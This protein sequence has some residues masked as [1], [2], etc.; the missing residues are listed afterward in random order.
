M[1]H[2]TW[3][4]TAPEYIPRL[5]ISCPVDCKSVALADVQREKQWLIPMQERK[6]VDWIVDS[7]P[8]LSDVET[9]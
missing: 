8:M 4:V 5:C 3:R 7:Q 2:L 6:L 1:T 9:S